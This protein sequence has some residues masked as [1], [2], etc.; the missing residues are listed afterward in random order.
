VIYI[1]N[2]LSFLLLPFYFIILGL[3]IIENKESKERLKERF[4][5]SSIKRPDGNLIWLHAASMGES[6]IVITLIENISIKYPKV[7]FLVTSGTSSSANIL[8]KKLPQNAIHQFLPIDNLIFVRKFFKTWR[9]DLGIFIESELWPCLISEGAKNCKLLL[10]NARISDKSFKSWQKFS[11]LFRSVTMNFSEIIVQSSVDFDKFIALGV[12][13]I[14]N[15]GNIK[16]ANKKLEVNKIEQETL[17]KHFVGKQIIVLASTH[18]EDE[19]ALLKVIRP[20]KSEYPNCYF[21]LILRHPERNKDVAKICQ[22]LNLSFSIRSEV[23]I[24]ILDDEL[25]IVDKF[26]ELGLFYSIADISFVGGSF[27]HGG[28]NLL[29]PAFFENLILFGPDMS[30]FFIIAQEM[31]K[32]KASIQ[33]KNSD[34]LL[35]KLQYFLNLSNIETAKVYKK[36]ALEFVIKNQ[37]ILLDYLDVLSKYI[38]ND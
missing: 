13:K 28:H 11:L 35:E 7:N 33:I 36:N 27:K 6:L 15:L 1:Y 5:I 24:P 4:G 16:F 2:I 34:E 3:R 31:I 20:I 22:E 14:S 10:F 23:P 37:K 25:Y 32:N 12:S 30:N 29:E 21:I 26:G 8:Q 38:K 17:V 9:P 19:E 18:L